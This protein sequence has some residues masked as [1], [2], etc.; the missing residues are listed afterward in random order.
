MNNHRLFEL[1][2]PV[3]FAHRG[4]NKYAPENTLASFRKALE[5]GAQALELD[6]T[7]SKD[8]AVVVI[9]DDTVDRT[10]NGKG[11]VADLNLAEIKKLDAG[12]WFSKDFA[13][14][15]IPTLEEVLALVQDKALIN[16]EIKNAGKRNEEL[17]QKAAA[18][19][20]KEKK[21]E[22]I[23]FSSFIPKNVCIIRKI[24]PEC[25]AGLL[26]LPGAAG[27]IEISLLGRVSPD[28]I[29]P[30]Y[31]SVSARFIERRHAHLKRVH[32]YTVNDPELMR[33]LARWNVDGFFCD[34]LV[35]AQ[36]VL[37]KISY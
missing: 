21:Q 1:A 30:H 25:P 18:L 23:I 29:H 37:A 26:T 35:L 31:S 34:D 6:I 33:T 9:H 20:V 5:L 32:T 19:V 11:A 2:K 24:L 16:I 8:G 14:E 13:G 17:V 15:A 28:L 36:Q 10:T 12:A 7:L 4:A 22:S 27:K 3:V